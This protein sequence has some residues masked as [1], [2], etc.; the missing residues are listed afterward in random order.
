MDSG[1]SGR[2][3]TRSAAFTIKPDRGVPLGK[4]SEGIVGAGSYTTA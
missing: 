2:G 3:P 1:G 4:L